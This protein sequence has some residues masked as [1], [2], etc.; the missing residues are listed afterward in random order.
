M[1]PLRVLG[2]LLI[3][4]PEVK[5][6]TGH[7]DW[8]VCIPLQCICWR[9]L[10]VFFSF[11]RICHLL[12]FVVGIPVVSWESSHITL[13]LFHGVCKL[14]LWSR[15]QAWSD[16]GGGF[17]A[18]IFRRCAFPSEGAGCLV[19]CLVLLRRSSTSGP[20]F[21]V[22][23]WKFLTSFLSQVLAAIADHCLELLLH[24]WAQNTNTSILPSRPSSLLGL[25]YKE[26]FVSPTAWLPSRTVC[27][28][29]AG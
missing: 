20:V 4:F 26:I 6:H 18:R 28:R 3:R 1:V 2:H 10:R 22:V 16:D 29:K 8:H 13:S 27:S 7:F 21:K 14:A 24:Q 12:H 23:P 11:W 15:L 19:V 25:F 5:S 17:S 9:N